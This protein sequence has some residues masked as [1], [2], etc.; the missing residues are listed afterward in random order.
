MKTLTTLMVLVLAGCNGG[1]RISSAPVAGDTITLPSIEW[2]VVDQAQ[3]IAV[4][5]KSGLEVPEGQQLDGFAGMDSRGVH[6]VYT[7]P[8]RRVDDQVT[9]TLGHEVMHVALGKYHAERK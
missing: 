7:L 8:P 5:R 9:C 2:R 4:Y 1:E 3:L 6:V